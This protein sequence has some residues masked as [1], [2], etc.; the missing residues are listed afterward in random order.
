M[1]CLRDNLASI[2]LAPQRPA[3]QPGPAS[4]LDTRRACTQPRLRL[5]FY[6]AFLTALG[7]FLC[8]YR[9]GEGMLVGDE[10]AFAST[11]DLM[12]TSGDWVVPRIVQDRPHLN[13]APLY[14]WLTLLS[15]GWLPE[16]LFRYRAW[17]ALFGV[18]C[19]LTAL[20]LGALLFRAEV[21]LLAGVLLLTNFRFLFWHAARDGCMEAGLAFL[22]T[23]VVLVYARLR[24]GTTRPMLHWCL[25]GAGIGAAWL[26]KPPVMG[27]FFFAAIALHHCFVDRRQPWLARLAGPAAALA[28]A[29]ILAAPWY[30]LVWSRLGDHS[31]YVLL[32]RNAVGRALTH[33]DVVPMR[34]SFAYWRGIWDSSCAFRLALPA[35]AWGG[36]CALLAWRRRAWLLLAWVAGTFV[37]ALSCSAEQRFHH[38]YAVFP[39]LSVMIA[40]MLLDGFKPA[41]LSKTWHERCHALA[42]CTGTAFLA[43]AL[44]RDIGRVRAELRRPMWDYP[45]LAVQERLAQVGL[46]QEVRLVLYQ[47]PRAQDS[48]LDRD[49][50]F[51]F[52][53]RYYAGLLSAAV[54][55]GYPSELNYLLRDGR[56]T[57]VFLPPKLNAA[58]FAAYEL[59]VRLDGHSMLRSEER[60]YPLLVVSGALAYPQVEEI[61][62]RYEVRG[63]LGHRRGGTP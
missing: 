15:E 54:H 46:L 14:N 48:K 3:V 59:E 37:L 41:A 34:E 45:P 6:A 57:L 2:I 62:R 52:L 21:G 60:L 22:V 56:P 19:G 11:T 9:L 35:F 36:L 58:D 33:R 5:L 44:P 61:V 32:V 30:L 31:M 24:S 28:V 43:V 10:A 13:A 26:M 7:S 38:I 17:S 50:G 23:A 49:S 47:Y 4:A 42:V 27:G 53:D 63:A 55:A 39:I 1:N 40:A 51:L 18:A 8:F 25:V 20:A 29:V 16:G 12:R